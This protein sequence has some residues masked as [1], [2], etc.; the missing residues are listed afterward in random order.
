MA[1][2]QAMSTNPAAGYNGISVGASTYGSS[3]GSLYHAGGLLFGRS[4]RLPESERD[5]HQL[6]SGRLSI[7]SRRDRMC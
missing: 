7:L 6:G 4:Q 3:I 1:M 2:A 5:C